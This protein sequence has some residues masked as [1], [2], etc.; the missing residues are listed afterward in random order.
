MAMLIMFEL[1]QSNNY[2]KN[3]ICLQTFSFKLLTISPFMPIYSSS[4]LEMYVKF[5]QDLCIRIHIIR[6][7]L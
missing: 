6:E 2:A 5:Y 7:I 3:R 4:M 1:I